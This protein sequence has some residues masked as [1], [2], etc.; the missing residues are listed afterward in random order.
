MGP[1]D[2]LHALKRFR[3]LIHPSILLDHSNPLPELAICLALRTL[4]QL[5]RLL[6]DGE[7]EV[8]EA[9]PDLIGCE[10][11]GGNVEVLGLVLEYL[12]LSA[13]T[14]G[15]VRSGRGTVLHRRKLTTVR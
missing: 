3:P 7:C 4:A 11:S 6:E 15:N 13:R 8:G 9:V 2:M 5:A 14:P 12:S 1:T 10:G